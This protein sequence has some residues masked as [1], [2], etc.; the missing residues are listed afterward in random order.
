MREL[1]LKQKEYKA[2]VQKEKKVDFSE[3]KMFEACLNKETE[4]KPVENRKKMNVLILALGSVA[5]NHFRRIFPITYKYLT[6]DLYENIFYERFNKI[7]ENAYPNFLPAFTGL[8]V[9]SY[10]ELNISNELSFYKNA[11]STF[12]DHFPFIWKEFENLGYLTQYNEEK[13]KL[14][15]FNLN[16]KGFR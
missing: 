14:G 6:Q 10:K 7:G 3:N 16:R 8:V 15:M 2:F 11:D 12:H 9:D 5:K 4:I 1:K 13:A